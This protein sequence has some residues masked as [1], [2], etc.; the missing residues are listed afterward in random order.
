M[1]TTLDK[2]FN[3]S[4]TPNVSKPNNGTVKLSIADKNIKPGKYNVTCLVY[5]KTG[6]AAQTP[7]KVKFTITVK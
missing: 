1:E 2:L 6:A 3:V 7:V 5:Y 4:F